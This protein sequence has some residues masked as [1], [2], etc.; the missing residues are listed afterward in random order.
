MQTRTQNCTSQCEPAT[1]R[2]CCF[3]QVL[4][5]PQLLQSSH[6]L[7]Q[8][9]PWVWG[10]GVISLCGW[11]LRGHLFSAQNQ[12]WADCSHVFL[13]AH[14]SCGC[15]H[16]THTRSS[17]SVFQSGVGRVYEVQPLTDK[18]WAIHSSWKRENLLRVWLLYGWPHSSVWSQT[19]IYEQY[20]R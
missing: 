13:R 1:P 5:N 8:G 4:P 15:P 20:K 11:A 3:V 6:L 9:G 16:K 7:S 10:K 18:F 19:Y 12:L 2:K 14:S 17:Q